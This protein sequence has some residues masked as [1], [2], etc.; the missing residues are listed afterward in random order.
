M[1]CA[2]EGTDKLHIQY[3]LTEMTEM[4]PPLMQGLR[5][6]AATYTRA[7]CRNA[8]VSWPF[9]KAYDSWA[10]CIYSALLNTK[11]R[12]NSDGVALSYYIITIAKTTFLADKQRFAAA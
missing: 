6:R 3:R 8:H 4:A 7:D 10:T 5:L 9:H 11:K 1:K 2:L 12:N